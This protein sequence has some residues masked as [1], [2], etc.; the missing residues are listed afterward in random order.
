MRARLSLLLWV[1]MFLAGTARAQSQ[2]QTQ[3]PPPPPQAKEESLGELARR[4][5]AKKGKTEPGKV[6][7]EE[8]LSGMKSSGVSV[9]GSQA[10]ATE[11][12]TPGKEKPTAAPAKAGDVPKGE[13]YWKE[14]FTDLRK[15]I[16]QADQELSV[17]QRELEIER[18]QDGGQPSESLRMS[19]VLA[20][21]Q[22]FKDIQG[23]I[24]AR[25]AELQKHKQEL[26]DL[27]DEF[28]RAGGEPGWI[29]Q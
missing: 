25:K 14:R 26:A 23:K 9:V 5:R 17:L 28:R 2:P 21:S 27:E 19:Q 4:A 8:D 13:A 20:N 24:E 3:P 15:K 11:T 1:V 16:A 7:T 29:R 22:K 18:V 6:Y 12:K 10:P